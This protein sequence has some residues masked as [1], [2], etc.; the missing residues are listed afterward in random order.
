MSTLGFKIF[1]FDINALAR[2]GLND[3]RQSRLDQAGL[4]WG[5]SAIRSSSG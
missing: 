1:V 3:H 2:P 5:I 4:A